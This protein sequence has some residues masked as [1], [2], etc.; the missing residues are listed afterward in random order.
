MVSAVTD[1][2]ME[3]AQP[4][5]ELILADELPPIPDTPRRKRRGKHIPTDDSRRQVTVLA[6]SGLPRRF[7]A[8]VLGIDIGSLNRNYRFELD[9]GM[10]RGYGEAA[11][12]LQKAVR[13]GEPW[14]ITKKLNTLPE[15]QDRQHV[16]VNAVQPEKAPELPPDPVEAERIYREFMQG[17]SPAAVS[18]P[19]AKKQ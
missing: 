18:L 17:T 5:Q 16:E 12:G 13:A 8:M 14:A 9:M 7:I 3:T 1:N 6:L 19:R 15:F 4:A 10:A 2:D 11:I